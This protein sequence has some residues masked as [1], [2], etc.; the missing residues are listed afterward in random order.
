MSELG[1]GIALK[2]MAGGGGVST[3]E[4]ADRFRSQ[5]ARS[6]ERA[7]LHFQAK[8]REGRV[9]PGEQQDWSEEERFGLRRWCETGPFTEPWMTRQG[10]I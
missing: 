8:G 10:R 1:N 2:G 3:V 7:A 9:A 4:A 6:P 5:P